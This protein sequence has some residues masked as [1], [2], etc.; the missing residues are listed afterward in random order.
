MRNKALVVLSGGQDSTT[1][2]FWAKQQFDEVFTITFDYGQRHKA[3]IA[4]ACNVAALAG[5]SL[6]NVN[7][8]KI[9]DV[10]LSKSPLV[11]NTPLREYESYDAM[12]AEVG[13][14]REAT[15]VPMR[16]ALF[17][18]I[19]ANYA[20]M[21]GCKTIVTGVCQM[22]SANYDDCRLS[23]ISAMQDCVTQSLGY[24]KKSPRDDIQIVAPL[25]WLSKA[26]TVKL[27]ESLPG[28][29]EGLAYSHTSY[30]G[31]YPP[32]GKNH[33]NLLRAHGFLEAGLPDPLVVRAYREGLMQLPDTPNYDSVRNE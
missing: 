17:L 22:D 16:N 21:L 30:D 15:F 12:V 19:A 1:C 32:T 11:S 6:E 13:D 33:A 3:E 28:C 24:D 5:L 10:L 9:P 23:F 7:F 18:V 25:I 26:Q 20:E 14:T 2:L 27:A 4:A 8:V 31:K 29:M